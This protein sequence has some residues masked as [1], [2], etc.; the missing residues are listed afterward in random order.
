MNK[1]TSLKLS[2][3]LAD[4]GFEEESEYCHI[5]DNKTGIKMI[6]NKYNYCDF[7]ECEK[8]SHYKSYDILNDLCVKYAK[9]MFGEDIVYQNMI[10][11]RGEEVFIE[12]FKNDAI[13]ILELLQQNKQDEAEEYIWENC[14]FNP[15]NKII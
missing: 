10:D 12:N 4:N 2:K 13:M 11:F 14:L 8:F 5:I 15:K 1:Y 9:E 6:T 7:S 3:L